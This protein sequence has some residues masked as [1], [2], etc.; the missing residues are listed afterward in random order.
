[1]RLNL[2]AAVAVSVAVTVLWCLLRALCQAIACSCCV[3]GGSGGF[4]GFG[5]FGG[6]AM[7]WRRILGRERWARNPVFRYASKE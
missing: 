1:M 3:F 6:L 7:L 4:G 2:V 5:G